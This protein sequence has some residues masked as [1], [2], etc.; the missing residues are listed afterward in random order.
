MI[1]PES[2]YCF[3]EGG[4]GTYSD[5]K[6]YT[7]SGK[8]GSIERILNIFHLFGADANILYEAHPHIGTNKLPQIIT[9]MREYIEQHGGEVRFNSK[10]TDII[11]KDNTIESVTI[12][13]SENISTKNLILATGH[14]AR[15]IFELLYHKKIYIEAKPFALGV[16]VEHP[17][18]IID[19]IQ[20]HGQSAGEFLPPSSYSLVDQQMGRGVFSFVCVRVVLLLPQLR[21]WA[22]WW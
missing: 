17:Q 16:R 7:R 2:N 19:N 12:N 5:G 14:S 6:L 20:Y 22:K 9:A 15:D 8:R 4:A 1:N 18:H 11:Y 10:L 3:G 13:D 21:R